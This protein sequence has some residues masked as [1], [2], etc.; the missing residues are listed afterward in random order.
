MFSNEAS[1][2]GRGGPGTRTPLIAIH[3]LS[4]NGF[5]HSEL[6]VYPGTAAAPPDGMDT[7]CFLASFSMLLK[8][9]MI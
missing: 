4:N 3:L 7:A 2:S 5:K 8:A 6:S 1:S 9:G